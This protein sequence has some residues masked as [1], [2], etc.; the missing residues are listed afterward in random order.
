MDK[1]YK[2]LFRADGG[3]KLGMGHIV[4]CCSIAEALRDVK[5]ESI[6]VCSDNEVKDYICGK[7]F[8][9]FSTNVEFDD[10]D[11]DF[12]EVVSLSKKYNCSMFVIDTYYASNRYISNLRNWGLI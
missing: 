11:K 10:V 9:F 1:E 7:G 3:A 5:I 8:A 2:V 6:F 4:R 12:D